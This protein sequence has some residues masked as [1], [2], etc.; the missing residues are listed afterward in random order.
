[1]YLINMET[2]ARGAMHEAQSPEWLLAY[3]T[4]RTGLLTSNIGEV[5]AFLRTRSGDEAP[6][7]QY[8]GAPASASLS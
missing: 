4:R 6:D 7:M 5:G 2:T 1:M 3:L 8:I